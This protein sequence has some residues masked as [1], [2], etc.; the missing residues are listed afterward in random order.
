[1]NL[2]AALRQGAPAQILIHFIS[3]ILS[4]S[5]EKRDFSA[6]RQRP[7]GQKSTLVHHLHVQVEKLASSVSV[8]CSRPA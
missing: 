2:S 5:A 4:D 1:M 3:R 6:V 8:A 7:V